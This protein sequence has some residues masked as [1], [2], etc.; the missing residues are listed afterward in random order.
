MTVVQ[1]ERL[2]RAAFAWVDQ[3]VRHFLSA[4]STIGMGFDGRPEGDTIGATI[5]DVREFSK[6]Y[7]TRMMPNS[8]SD[9]HPW[10]QDAMLQRDEIACD[11]IFDQRDRAGE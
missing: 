1:R 5:D 9:R 6:K 11:M 3:R 7:T 4:L 10:A 8:E 2:G